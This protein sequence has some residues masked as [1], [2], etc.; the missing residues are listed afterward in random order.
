MSQNPPVLPAKG[1]PPFWLWGILLVATVTVVLALVVS[2][3][4][5]DPAELYQDALQQL[6]GGNKEDFTRSFNQLKQYPDYSDH[7]ILLEGMKAAAEIR[8]PKAIELFE[9]AQKNATLKPLALQ[10]AGESLTRMGQFR[11]A[12][13]RYEEAI[14]TAP[15]TAHHSRLLLAQ[16]YQAVG[17]L[18]L[19]ET[20]LNQVIEGDETHDR[21]YLGALRMRAQVRNDLLRFEEAVVDFSETLATPG[22][23]AAARPDVITSYAK[24]LLKAGDT[25]RTAAL[26]EQHLYL[27]DDNSLKAQLLFQAGDVEGARELIE[28]QPDESGNSPESSKLLMQIAL[29][30]GDPKAA[31]GA[32]LEAL[33]YAPR[34]AEI[35]QIAV[36]VY[37]ETGDPENV[38]VAEQNVR[39]LED[40]KNQ[41]LDAMAAVGDNIDDVDGRFRVAEKMAELGLYNE[42]QKWFL[43]GGA[44]DP[45]RGP[46]ADRLMTEHLRLPAPLVSF[47]NVSLPKKEV[48]TD[49]DETKTEPPPAA[50]P[51]DT[52][53]PDQT[54]SDAEQEVTLPESKA[55][56]GSQSP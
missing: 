15:E 16:L 53:K 24:C 21:T 52:P 26:V 37:R 38:D 23:V 56:D 11:E 13:D 43:K 14:E 41:L 45:E 7:I 5:D 10:K 50:T 36:S 35:F 33:Q 19:A 39:Q 2:A 49:T 25:E 28:S 46:D 22:D 48:S 42:A 18:T 54:Q 6:S 9:Q 1:G 29:S 34:N 3:V 32:L 40:L 30:D 8:D 4:P 51:E 27:I 12:I 20:T 47:R 44:I 17:A 55:E 31:E